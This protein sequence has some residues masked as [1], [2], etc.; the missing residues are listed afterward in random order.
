MT[1]L[2][3]LISTWHTAPATTMEEIRKKEI[4]IGTTGGKQGQAYIYAAMMKAF[5]GAKF[6]IIGGYA[7]SSSLNPALERGEIHGR[8]NSWNSYM[9]SHPDWISGK[10]I[11]PL[12]QIGLK[13]DPNLPNV[14]MVT[15]F[16]TSDQGRKVLELISTTSAFSRAVWGPPEMPKEALAILRK[17][18]DATM[19]DPAVRAD[20]EKRKFYL[21]PMTGAEVEAEAVRLQSAPADV[22]KAAKAALLAK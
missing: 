10:K 5:T 1:S 6:R 11:I 14:P 8:S 3:G 21:D 7:G 2:T 22:V 19:N 18:F 4:I 13:K 15:E 12:V 20:A 17:S 9:I 16:A